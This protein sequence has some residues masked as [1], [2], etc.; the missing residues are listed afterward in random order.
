[1]LPL[2][3]LLPVAAVSPGKLQQTGSG[4]GKGYTINI[5]LP[6]ERGLSD[7]PLAGPAVLGPGL[8]V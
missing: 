6:G 7:T 5:P 1:L 3:L 2:L 4:K 8:G